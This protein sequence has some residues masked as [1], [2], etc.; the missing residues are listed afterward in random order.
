MFIENY[1]K[2]LEIPV[3][4]G[5]PVEITVSNSI[6]S[7]DISLA[8]NDPM[9]LGIFGISNGQDGS[10]F[11]G[12]LFKGTNY[13]NS[14]SQTWSFVSNSNS[15]KIWVAAFGMDLASNPQGKFDLTVNGTLYEI[16]PNNIIF[17]ESI[18][19]AEK[20]TYDGSSVSCE[21]SNSIVS[22]DSGGESKE[23]PLL[24]AM[25]GVS[26]GQDGS[27]L[28]GEVFKGTNYYNSL[29]QTWNYTSNTSI[30]NLWAIPVGIKP[31]SNLTREFELNINNDYNEITP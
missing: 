7:Q 30:Q 17:L 4:A 26:N 3:T 8:Y 6:F 31:I 28:I 5:Q 12:K 1:S 24:L 20:L 11:V 27:E 9:L 18:K 29:K 19:E 23:D 21:I 25:F 13:Y 10:E 14:D 22:S 2:F 16:L 15:D